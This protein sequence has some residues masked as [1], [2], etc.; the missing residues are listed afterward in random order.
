MNKKKLNL[1]R[2]RIDRLDT[3]IF[4]LIKKRTRIV[5]HMLDLK[6]NKKQIIDHKRIKEILKKI[7][8]KSLKNKIDIK[9]TR[10]IWASMIWS[11]VDY[12]KRNFKKK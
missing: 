2:K 9:L 4:N 3:K 12:Q 1:A 6:E 10:R 7:K 8:N 5:Q 11:Y